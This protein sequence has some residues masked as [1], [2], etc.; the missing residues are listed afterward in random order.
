MQ[1]L[2][3]EGWAGDP[4]AGTLPAGNGGCI[5]GKLKFKTPTMKKEF[6]R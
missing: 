1:K 6:K 4:N 5:L 3:V 2:A